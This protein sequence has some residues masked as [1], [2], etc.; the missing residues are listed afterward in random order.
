MMK[1]T[2]A[3]VFFI[4]NINICCYS[5]ES[6]DSDCKFPLIQSEKLTFVNQ[7]SSDIYFYGWTKSPMVADDNALLVSDFAGK[8]VKIL[9][10]ESLIPDTSASSNHYFRKAI[11]DDC[12]VVYARFY[13]DGTENFNGVITNAELIEQARALVKAKSYIGKYFWV[14][15]GNYPL[16]EI[17]SESGQPIYNLKKFYKFTVQDVYTGVVSGDSSGASIYL[18]II[19]EDKVI[20]LFPFNESYILK[21]N[22]L[23]S[24]RPARIVNAIKQ[25]EVVLGMTRDE[26]KL[27]WGEPKDINR[28]VGNWGVHEQWVYDGTYLYFKNGVLTSFQD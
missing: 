17:Y 19:T 21:N 23:S 4:V 2:I 22:P 27:S 9:R 24:K 8:Y 25:E 20:G 11:V 14:N 12:R 28:T 16:R 5:N 1:S 6:G 13:A 15:F 7:S 26:V 3:W 10:D 18:K